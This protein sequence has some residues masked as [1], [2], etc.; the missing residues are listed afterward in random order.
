MCLSNFQC[1]FVCTV[2]CTHFHHARFTHVHRS[3]LISI[4]D[5]ESVPVLSIQ[6]PVYPSFQASD[7]LFRNESAFLEIAR[8]DLGN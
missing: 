6:E 7:S 3:S 2:H 4:P 5:E 1:Y 8:I